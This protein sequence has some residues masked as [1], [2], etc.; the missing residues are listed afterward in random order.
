[1]YRAVNCCVGA[2]D[3]TPVLWESSQYSPPLSRF[4]SVQNARAGLCLREFAELRSW[5]RAVRVPYVTAEK[6]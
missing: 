1:M 2:G 4:S 5:G 6:G 3:R